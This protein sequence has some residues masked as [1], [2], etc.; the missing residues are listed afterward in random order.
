M[1]FTVDTSNIVFCYFFVY[2]LIKKVELPLEIFILEETISLA[3]KST[4]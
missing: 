3:Q 1:G 4:E 2:D